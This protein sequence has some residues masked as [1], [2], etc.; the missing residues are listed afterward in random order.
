MIT[1]NRFQI[2]TFC[3]VLGLAM[4][5]FLQKN[6]LLCF[7]I[8]S[9]LLQNIPDHKHT[10]KSLRHEMLVEDKLTIMIKTIKYSLK[11]VHELIR[12]FL[13]IFNFDHVFLYLWIR[14]KRYKLVIFVRRCK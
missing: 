11:G 13:Y 10:P 12:T 5:F 2:E 8:A 9:I 7:L 1:Y 14:L 3:R 6:T 4:L